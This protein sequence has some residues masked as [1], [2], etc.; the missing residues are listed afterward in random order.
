MGRVRPL[1]AVRRSAP[2]DPAFIGRHPLLWPLARAARAL[3]PFDDFPPV[4]ALAGVFDRADGAA[5]VRFA[6][7]TPRRGR[8]KR[9]D[10]RKLYDARIALD[11]EVPTRARCWHDLM[12]A[13]VWGTFPRSKHALHAR[14]HEAIGERLTP[15]ARTLPASRSR[16][17]D[18]LALVDEGGIALL[19]RS[20][21]HRRALR[22]R[23]GHGILA[24][25]LDSRTVE[26][27]IFGHAIYESL[28]LGVKPAVVAGVIV[29]GE[30]AEADV[31]RAVDRGLAR[32][33]QDRTVLRS[34]QEFVRVDLHAALRAT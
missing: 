24:S 4:E 16:E 30:G 32:M 1:V 13:L 17:L 31:L 33:L 8:G 25:H 23:G 12:N 6:H 34:P 26:T 5:P 20:E 29:E 10:P 19:P 22:D 28:V 18:A 27:V 15:G 2:F 11:G 21:S 3:E 14:Q 7:A 9:L